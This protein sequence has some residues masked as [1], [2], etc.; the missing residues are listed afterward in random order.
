M[1]RNEA[2]SC[3]SGLG[4]VGQRPDYPFTAD[5][6]GFWRSTELDNCFIGIFRY[7]EQILIEGVGPIHG[8]G[9]RGD[10]SD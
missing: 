1:G 3:D 9:R 2:I 6:S 7:L 10:E 5:D 8:E 4:F